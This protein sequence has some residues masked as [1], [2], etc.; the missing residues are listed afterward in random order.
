MQLADAVAGPRACPLVPKVTKELGASGKAVGKNFFL[1]FHV[2]KTSVGFDKVNITSEE[3]VNDLGGELR[4]AVQGGELILF[5]EA[6]VSFVVLERISCHL[7]GV[8]NLSAV[9]EEVPIL[10]TSDEALS[11]VQRTIIE[12]GV[13]GV[14]ALDAPSR[15]YIT[16]DGADGTEAAKLS[17]AA[18]DMGSIDKLTLA[19]QRLFDKLGGGDVDDK[20]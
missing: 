14:N 1:D 17:F 8:A 18:L 9:G 7:Q 13:V 10:R 3:A 19:V 6:G 20:R 11:G 5:T 2:L 15:T 12:A 4:L 16:E